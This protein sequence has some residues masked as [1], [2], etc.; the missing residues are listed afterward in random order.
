MR[1]RQRRISLRVTQTEYDRTEAAAVKDGLTLA[2]YARL[3]LID[4]PETRTRRR[5]RADVAALSKTH[6][7]LNRIGGNINQIARAVNASEPWGAAQL[8]E[9]I[10]E[11]RE[12]LGLVRAAM[13][14]AS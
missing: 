11:L 12:A 4:E 7:E 10:A 2:S 3:K 8:T 6:G 5:P 9:A 14:Y 1:Q 13:G